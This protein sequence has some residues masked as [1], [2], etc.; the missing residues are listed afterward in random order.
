MNAVQY[1]FLDRTL[2]MSTGKAAAQASHASVEGV[3]AHQR[4]MPSFNSPGK[5]LYDA[6][7]TG[8]HYAKV[9]LETDDLYTTKAYLES[10]GFHVELIIDEGR[11]EFGGKLTPTALGTTIV[12]K[13]DPHTRATFQEFDIYGTYER[14]L[15]LRTARGAEPRERFVVMSPHRVS[16]SHFNRVRDYLRG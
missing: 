16:R 9:V 10:R 1:I 2:N 4:S 12:D 15:S 5:P 13:D 14:K 3:L 7:R 8:K 6:W 11:T